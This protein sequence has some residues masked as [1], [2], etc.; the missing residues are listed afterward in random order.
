M[1]RAGMLAA[2]GLVVA[3]NAFVLGRAAWNRAGEPDASMALT[4]R[5][6]S[7]RYSPRETE[8]SAVALHLELEHLGAWLPPRDPEL[9]TLK[10][11]DPVKLAALGFDVRLPSN[12]ADAASF[13]SRQPARG[14]YAVVEFQGPTWNAYRAV[15]ERK[16]GQRADPEPATSAEPWEHQVALRELRGGSRLFLV[17]AGTDAA[18][19]RKRYPH[20]GTY[21]ILPAKVGAHL[22]QERGANE[23]GPASCRARGSITLLID[24]VV[25]PRRLHSV[26]PLAARVGQDRS[27]LAEGHEPRYE[28]TLQSGALHE[29]WVQAIRPLSGASP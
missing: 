4:E 16:Y 11:L 3:V 1:T 9:D 13:L 2:A 14:A 28:V 29:P 22:A 8:S 25:V 12:P 5:E 6:L 7:I 17:D 26:L 15:L 23:C 21:L 20:R 24:E 19:L 10:W 18:V 27:D